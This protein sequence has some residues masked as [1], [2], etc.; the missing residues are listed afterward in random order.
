MALEDMI[1][2]LYK[3]NMALPMQYANPYF[4]FLGNQSNNM[5]GV[6]NAYQGNVGSLGNTYQGGV[7]GLGNTYQGNMGSIGTNSI[8]QAGQLGASAM[9]L[10]GGLANT[11]ANMYGSEMPARMEMAR[12]NA[13]GPALS[14]LLG[15]FGGGAGDAIGSYN[16]DFNRPD[17]MSGYQGAVDNSYNQ[18]G[19]VTGNAYG[20]AS[21]AYGGAMGNA[22]AAY[23]TSQGNANAAYGT[24][25]GGVQGYD[26]EFKNQWENMQKRA[27]PNWTPDG[28][29]PQN[30]PVLR[31]SPM[32]G[33]QQPPGAAS[34][35]SNEGVWDG[36]GFVSA[37]RQPTR[38]P[39]VA[40]Y[41]PDAYAMAGRAMPAPRTGQ[42]P[43]AWG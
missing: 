3:F 6:G 22:N 15:Q 40:E 39:G 9:G 31:K 30:Q 8:N 13:L 7:A 1:G 11:Q 14:G 34:V 37:P 42:R 5:A 26:K 16:M 2:D 20:Q 38:T 12:F 28:Q 36:S 43:A 41:T 25:A 18:L 29:Q 33:F 4:Q 21:N 24:G 35:R 10:Y 23:N 17:V 32:Q 19:N 27:M